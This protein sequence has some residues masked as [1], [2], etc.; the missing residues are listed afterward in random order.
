MLFVDAVLGRRLA[1]V[2]EDRRAVGD[3]LGLGF[4]GLKL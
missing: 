3:R 2:G 1:E 4:H